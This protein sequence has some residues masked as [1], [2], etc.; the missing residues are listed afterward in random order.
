MAFRLK[1]GDRV[2]I[3]SGEHKGE[4]GKILRV[5]KKKETLQKRSE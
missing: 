3:V 1:R 5:K 2:Q 4:E